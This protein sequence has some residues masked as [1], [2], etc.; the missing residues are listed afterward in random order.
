S[1]TPNYVYKCQRL[2]ETT[3]E[4][5]IK[6]G[7]DATLEYY[8]D[9]VVPYETAHYMQHTKIELEEGA[10]LILTDGITGGWS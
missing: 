9:E 4:T 6:V 8:L 5:I 10:S 7:K 1:Q 3:Q 2:I